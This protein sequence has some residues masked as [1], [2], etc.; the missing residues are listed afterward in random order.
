MSET[1]YWSKV[2]P[3]AIIPTKRDEDAGYD[4]YCCF[5]E[6]YLIIEPGETKMIGLGIASAF[7]QDYVVFLKE[8]GSTAKYG[9]SVRSGVIDSGYRGE[10][11]LAITNT[12]IQSVA[13]TKEGI[14]LPEVMKKLPPEVNE[15]GWAP[16]VLS[17]GYFPIA[18]QIYPYEKAICQAVVLPLPKL[19]SKEIPYEQ[20]LEKKSERGTGLMGSSGK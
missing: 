1:I 15:Y 14:K 2:K 11:V 9:L 19:E 5:D 12:G 3:E 8:R 7:P 6:D 17:Y 18:D 16:D 4:L 13:I 10:Y 20:L